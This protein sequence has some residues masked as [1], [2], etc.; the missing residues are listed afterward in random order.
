MR[1]RHIRIKEFGAEGVRIMRPTPEYLELTNGTLPDTDYTI[2][3]DADGFVCD[4]DADADPARAPGAARPLYV[5]GDS[6]V[7]SAFVPQGQRVADRIGQG[8]AA[9]G[10]ARRVLNGG[11]SGSTSLNLFDTIIN[12]IGPRE[13]A[14]VLHVLPSND[15]LSMR[16]DDGFWNMGS[17]RYSPIL[18]ARKAP[19]EPAA[20]WHPSPAQ[21]RMTLKAM[22]RTADAFG[23][24]LFFAT[25]PYVRRGY[26]RLPWYRKRHTDGGESY[27]ALI[28]SRSA[29]NTILREVAGLCRVPLVDLEVAM[30][31]PRHFYDDLHLN[32]EGSQAMADIVVETFGPA[33]G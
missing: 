8:L 32:T 4:P 12:K 11:Y 3:T 21:L 26:E 28:A 33:L 19:L 5:L 30:G 20:P 13:G 17:Q 2:T 15:V 24:H 16:D 1:K 9:R 6:L 23:I 10:I 31:D 18:P 14:A 27:D 7:E 22:A 29:N 25:T